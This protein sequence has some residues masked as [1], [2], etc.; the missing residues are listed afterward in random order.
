MIN[1]SNIKYTSGARLSPRPLVCGA[2]SLVLSL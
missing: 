1:R 2:S